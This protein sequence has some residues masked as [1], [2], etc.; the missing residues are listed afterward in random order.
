VLVWNPSKAGDA[1]SIND[2]RLVLAPRS[3][4]S[5]L[6][7]DVLKRSD[8]F[9]PAASSEVVLDK[10]L[11]ADLSVLGRVNKYLGNS[12]AGRLIGVPRP[13]GRNQLAAIKLIGG[14]DGDCAKCHKEQAS[15]WATTR[16]SRA[17][18]TLRNVGKASRTDCI[19]CHTTPAESLSLTSSVSGIG[20]STC[21]GDA[22]RHL[23]NVKESGNIVRKPERSLCVT[24][25][26]E[27]S[28]P[29][30]DF[31]AYLPKVAH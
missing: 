27:E 28:S 29:H 5:L 16:H 25:H 12:S 10:R 13:V 7:V 3:G 24:C 1:G 6:V 17:F 19:V 15:Q 11:Q 8:H 21:H 14:A 20:C 31:K 18:I 23:A 30:F 26:T 4:G 9:E 2:S 22:S